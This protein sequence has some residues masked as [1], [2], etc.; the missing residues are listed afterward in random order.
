MES[1]K[2]IDLFRSSSKSLAIPFSINLD[3][4]ALQI[5]N[6]LFSK[7]N[8]ITELIITGQNLDPPKLKLIY[9]IIE[10]RQILKRLVLSNN[11]ISGRDSL[12]I[13]CAS[14]KQSQ[15]EY[16]DLSNNK[17]SDDSLEYISD[18]LENSNLLFL[19]L[20]SNSISRGTLGQAL[21]KNERIHTF[22]INSNPLSYEF[23]S[24]LLSSLMFNKSIKSFHM[25]G[26]KLEGPAPIKENS[27]GHLSKQEAIILKLAYVLRF[28]ICSSISIDL[29]PALEVQLE[30]LEKTLVKYNNRLTSINSDLIDWKTAP[31]NSVAGVI[32]KALKANSWIQNNSS[33][34]KEKQEALPSDIE[35]LVNNKMNSQNKSENNESFLSYIES[36][37]IDQKNV[38]KNI[39][40]I[41]S[42]NSSPSSP[43]FKQVNSK[44]QDFRSNHLTY[45]AET[46]QFM[47][48]KG[49][50]FSP[51]LKNFDRINDFEDISS[52]DFEEKR[53]TPV[54][55]KQEKQLEEMWNYFKNSEKNLTA[56]IEIYGFRLGN[57]E[58]KLQGMSKSIGDIKEIGERNADKENLEKSFVRKSEEKG[59]WAAISRIEKFMTTVLKK[60]QV[61]DSRIQGIEEEVKM[62][63]E[64]YAKVRETVEE[65][66]K[67]CNENLKDKTG[68]LDLELLEKKF[69]KLA[70]KFN[71][72]NSDIETIRR[73]I[74]RS[75]IN[76]KQIDSI[77]QEITRLKDRDSA[78]SSELLKVF[79]NSQKEIMA[80]YLLLDSKVSD[81]LSPKEEVKKSRFERTSVSPLQKSSIPTLDIPKALKLTNSNTEELSKR[82]HLPDRSKSPISTNENF[83]PGEAESLVMSVIMERANSTRLMQSMRKASK[84]PIGFRSKL[85]LIEAENI[86]SAQLQETLRLRGIPYESKGA[87]TERRK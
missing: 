34:P 61:F 63:K 19:N 58:D 22:S 72:V 15:I 16:L 82:I 5:L 44:K 10:S 4:N 9:S 83:L 24:D 51:E 71:F 28:S 2:L 86:P 81:L 66:K 65:F 49:I 27:S 57:L 50:T 74:S 31:S 32:Y 42:I 3:L 79:E 29:N 6:Q 73:E 84:S 85:N 75:Q 55:M 7:S 20:D 41:Y 17:I 68:K 25:K 77:C 80:K 35:E 40:N 48:V 53:C 46:P 23:L 64:N 12:E 11:K 33:I 36:D 52:I 21:S 13:I 37:F 45:S 26:I 67:S 56:Q 60:D 62:N 8:S 43:K 78:R 76:S 30:E 1:Q 14:V 47:T 54:K 69:L 70:N 87:L 59:I 18:M 39:S 38:K